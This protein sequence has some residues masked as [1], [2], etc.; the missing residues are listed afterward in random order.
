M[1]A[2]YGD[3]ISPHMTTTPEGFLICHD[4]PIARTG[5]MDYLAREIGLDGDP[6]KLVTVHRCQE[7]VFDAAAMASFEGKEVTCG[8]PAETVGPSNHAAY[9]KGHVQNVRRDGDYLVADLHIKDAALISDVRSGALREVSCGYNCRYIPDGDG[10]RQQHIRGNH[11]AVVPRG[12]AGHEVAIHDSA[13]LAGKGSNTM[14]KFAEAILKA[15][16][17]AAKDAK[18]DREM[19]SLVTTTMTALDAEPND[20]APAP[21]PKPEEEKPTADAAP[22]ALEEKLDKVISLLE[23]R[24]SKPE[25]PGKILDQMIEELEGASAEVIPAGEQ[26]EAV[27]DGPARD[28]ALSMLRSMRPVVASIEDTAT[29]RKVTDALLN[30]VKGTDVMGGIMQAV[31]KNAQQAADA[32]QTGTFEARC[33]ESEAAYAARNPHKKKED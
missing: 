6:D 33:R 29:Q 16:G 11:V 20:P 31:Q 19:N 30:A 5:D 15:F 8:H 3:R 24:D 28:A 26:E 25:A 22:S 18:D 7:D 1:L 21:E 4:V 9:S 2:Y 27:L 10:Y 14:S 23:A 12:R 17:M 32:A 13:V